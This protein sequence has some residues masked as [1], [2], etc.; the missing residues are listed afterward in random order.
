MSVAGTVTRI[1]VEVMEVGVSEPFVPKFTVAPVTKFVPLTVNVNA[2][3]PAVV[4]VGEI[5][6][7]VG[8][9]AVPVIVKVTGAELLPVKLASPL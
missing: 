6:E 3:P 4:L 9:P 8:V 1:C 5:D 2:A 7:I